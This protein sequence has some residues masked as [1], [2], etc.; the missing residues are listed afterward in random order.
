M[1]ARRRHELKENVLAREL[2][3]LREFFSR[4]GTWMLTGVIAAGLVVL[5]VTRVRS[6][7]RQALYAERVRYAELTRDASMKDDQRLKGLAELAETA[8]DPLTAANAAIA[9]ADLWSRK[10]VG[11]LIRSSS[12]EADEARRKAEEL[13]NLVLTRYPQQSRHVA[14]AHFGLG[15]LAESAGDKQAAEDHYSQAARMLN[16]GHPTVLE[17]ERRLAAL[18]DLREVKFATTLPTRPAATSAPATRPAASGP[19]EPAGK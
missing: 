14:K 19:S 2:V 10:Y 13:Y 9:A 12:S 7:R 4:Y 6:S 18:A 15:A 8:R 17:A 3:Q 1:K 16:R 5:I 11:A